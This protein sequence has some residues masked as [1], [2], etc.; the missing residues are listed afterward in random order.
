MLK[1]HHV[2]VPQGKFFFLSLSLLHT[3][4]RAHAHTH[5]VSN[6]FTFKPGTIFILEANYVL[7]IFKKWFTYLNKFINL[8]TMLWNSCPRFIIGHQRGQ[9]ILHKPPT[10]V[11]K[12]RGDKITPQPLIK[13][14]FAKATKDRQQ[15]NRD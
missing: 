15:R 8:V 1:R 14:T 4:M 10:E 11:T 9:K 7:C 6:I 2:L 3:H 12:P 5:T 13:L